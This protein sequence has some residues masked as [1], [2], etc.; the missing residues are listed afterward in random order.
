MGDAPQPN[1]RIKGKRFLLTYPQQ[2]GE[3]HEL[4]TFLDETKSI[5]RA[6]IAKEPHEAGG[7][8]F[9]AYIELEQPVDVR[10]IRLFDWNGKHPNIKPKRTKPEWIAA[11][12]YCRKGDDWVDFG[13][14]EA[15]VDDEVFDFVGAVKEAENFSDYLSKCYANNV[16]YGYCA[17]AWSAQNTKGSTLLDDTEIK[18]SISDP[19]LQ[20]M[21]FDIDDE[22]VLVVSGPTGVGKTTWAKRHIPK[23]A[24]WVRHVDQLKAFRRGFHVSILFDDFSLQHRPRQDQINLVDRYDDQAIHLRNT[25]GSIPAGVYK[26]FTC[27][28]GWSDYPVTRGDPALDR[29]INHVAL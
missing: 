23:P 11:A 21:S 6:V 28:Q 2:D 8:H 16:P 14:E 7:V 5:K 24:L 13:F 15:E 19:T 1:G 22:R 17:A 4:F 27:N 9:H 18:G 29:R 20:E 26:I 25:I 12:E 10:N 3:H